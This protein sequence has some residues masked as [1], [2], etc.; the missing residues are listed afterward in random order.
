MEFDD[1]EYEHFGIDCAF[2]EIIV[3]NQDEDQTVYL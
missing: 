2:F 3:L 1:Y